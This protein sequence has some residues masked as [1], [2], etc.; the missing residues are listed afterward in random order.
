MAIVLSQAK[1]F[2]DLNP[3][4]ASWVS[5]T[6][7]LLGSH[8][9]TPVQDHTIPLFLENKDVVD[10]GVT[11]SG[12]TLSFIIPIIERLIQL[13]PGPHSHVAAIIIS[14]T[15]ELAT[16]TFQ[17]VNQF[18]DNRPSTSDQENP[19]S[20]SVTPFLKAMLLIGGTGGRSIKQDVSE[21]Q[22][23]GAN[24]LVAIPGRLEEFLF[25]YSSLTKRKTND[26]CES[27]L[28][29]PFKT[30]VNLK[31]LEVLVLD[32]ADWSV[33]LSL[34]PNKNNRSFQ[35]PLRKHDN[36]GCKWVGSTQ[37]PLG[38]GSGSGSLRP[39]KTQANPTSNR[40]RVWAAC[41]VIGSTRGPDCDPVMG[42]CTA[43]KG[44]GNSKFGAVWPQPN[45]AP[46]PWGP[47]TQMRRI[48]SRAG[49]TQT[50]P[51]PEPL[52][53]GFGFG[54]PFLISDPTQPN[55]ACT[56]GR[57]RARFSDPNLKELQPLMTVKKS[58][59]V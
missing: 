31:N 33:E 19:S 47:S 22:E 57:V 24:I 38:W 13:E 54:Q 28:R 35:Y 34:S 58:G 44:C 39:Q 40:V 15:R 59:K 4:L 3:R 12:K 10:K 1:S 5:D 55:L 36:S 41:F 16:Q 32:K 52:V 6:I 9:M 17:V 29:T 45:L 46:R 37:D 42:T 11:G 30:L 56:S 50:Q 14:P 51:K 43:P 49:S 21:F 26:F 18:L 23:N 8:Q 48:P 27:K 7:K 20:S 2:D 53:T 25:G